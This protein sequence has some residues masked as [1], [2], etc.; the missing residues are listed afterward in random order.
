MSMTA[1]W[2]RVHGP[3][4]LGPHQQ[5][6]YTIEAPS[7]FAMP[8]ISNGFQVLAF[9][10]GPGI[11]QPDRRLRGQLWRVVLPARHDQPAGR[12]RPADHRARRDR[13]PARPA[14]PGRERARLPR[15]GHLRA[16]RPAVQPGHHQQRPARPDAGPS[17]DQRPGR[18]HVHDHAQPTASGNPVYFEANLVKPDSAYPYGYS[19]I[20]AVR[21]RQ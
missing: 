9:S 14:G 12:P 21:F 17:A 1:F 8:S 16:A 13:Q 4:A 10:H 18:R 3:P 11:G 7:Y 5:A 2:R 20:L 19:P 15:P 6:R